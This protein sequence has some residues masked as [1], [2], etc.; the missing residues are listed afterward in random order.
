MPIQI[1]NKLK[2]YFF[3]K[4]KIVDKG[5]DHMNFFLTECKFTDILC[6]KVKRQLLMICYTGCDYEITVRFSVFTMV[7]D[8]RNGIALNLPRMKSPKHGNFLNK[9]YRKEKS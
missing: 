6:E 5:V 1:N 4:G 3:Q 9:Y 8:E 7:L 2:K